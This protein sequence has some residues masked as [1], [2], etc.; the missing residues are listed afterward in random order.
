M[1]VQCVAPQGWAPKLGPTPPCL[2]TV[3]ARTGPCAFCA[4]LCSYGFVRYGSVAEAQAAIGSLDGTSVLG[5]TLQVKFADA[6]AGERARSALPLPV[7]SRA[8]Q[9]PA[10][11][12]ARG[13]GMRRTQPLVAWHPSTGKVSSTL[14]G[15]R[16]PPQR[17]Y[18]RPTGSS[19]GAAIQLTSLPSCLPRA[20]AHRPPNHARTFWPHALGQLLCEAPAGQLR[21]ARGAAAV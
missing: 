5:H 13:S 15:F 20:A 1:Q 3:Q 8:G 21:R 2:C 10:P 17:Q 7:K 18:R 6:D 19:Q 11:F 4:P 12:A 16:P 9:N 14:Q